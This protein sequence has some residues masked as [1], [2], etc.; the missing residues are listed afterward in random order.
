MNTS[1]GI[2]FRPGTTK[3]KKGSVDT[4]LLS[5]SPTNHE[6]Q[7]EL[8][9]HEENLYFSYFVLPTDTLSG[10]SIRFCINKEE[11]K[12]LNPI[13]SES[14]IYAFKKLRIR[15]KTANEEVIRSMEHDRKVL[16]EKLSFEADVRPHD[17]QFH[18]EKYSYNYS[19][20]LESAKMSRERWANKSISSI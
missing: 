16:I 14:N 19:K 9:P 15:R 2:H 7:R 6:E 11:L 8:S 5:K 20:A 12:A 13:V 4:S 1:S 17:A 3:E 10:I 18:L